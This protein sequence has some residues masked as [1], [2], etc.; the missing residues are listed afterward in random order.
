MKAQYLKLQKEV[1]DLKQNDT[2]A[3]ELAISNLKNQTRYVQEEIKATNRRQ[4]SILSNAD[5]RKQNFNRLY[6]RVVESERNIQNLNDSL[7]NKT[8]EMY[9]LLERNYMNITNSTNLIDTRL[10]NKTSTIEKRIHQFELTFYSNFSKI[11]NQMQGLQSKTLSIQTALNTMSDRGMYKF[12]CFLH[13][14]LSYKGILTISSLNFPSAI[15][16]IE[17]YAKYSI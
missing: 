3:K 6:R 8:L 16:F 5:I 7:S 1:S 12:I 11:T 9:Q 4:A 13:F 14:C 17:S 10:S 15:Y 2:T